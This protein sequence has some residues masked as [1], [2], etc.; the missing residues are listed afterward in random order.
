MRRTARCRRSTATCSKSR[1]A[2]GHGGVFGRLTKIVLPAA[3]PGILAG[4][5]TGVGQAW[6]S[7]VAAELFG[8]PA[9]ARA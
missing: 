6:M 1:R 7:V 3:A 4:I 5:R 9:S 2:F 8:V